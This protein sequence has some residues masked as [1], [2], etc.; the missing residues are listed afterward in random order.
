MHSG[1]S[2]GEDDEDD[3]ENEDEDDD[4]DEGRASWRAYERRYRW[5]AQPVGHRESTHEIESTTKQIQL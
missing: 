3:D 1:H 5:C 4:D 2:G